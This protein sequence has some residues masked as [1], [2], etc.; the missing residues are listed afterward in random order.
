MSSTPSAADSSAVRVVHRID[1][2]RRCIQGW[3]QAGQRISYVPTMGSLHAG[4]L[5]LVEA[6]RAHGDRVVVS[7]FV[8]PLQF[9]AGEDLDKYPRTLEADCA[10][11]ASCGTDLVFA[12]EEAEVYPYGRANLTQVAVPG[13]SSLLCGEY[14]AGHF[15]GVTTVVSLL[16]NLV[17]PDCAVFGLKDYQQLTIIRRMVRDLHVPVEIV[18]MP[19][20]REPGGLAMS[21][22]NIYLSAD[23]RAQAE[24]IYASLCEAADA[25]RA[26]HRDIAALEA[27]GCH[28]IDQAGLKTQFFQVRQADLEAPDDATQQFVVL[29]AA[30][31][32][33]TR[34]IDNV[35]VDLNLA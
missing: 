18:G 31:L 16:F 5:S 13:L 30:K 25:L 22:R 14:R 9:S 11:L 23:E 26:G 19:T 10:K 2:L 21:S 32:G 27:R 3:R 34:L 35:T 17:Q 29:A 12:P 20:L 7:I 1:E 6:A 8:N 24:V 4:H 33:G 15:E 28:R